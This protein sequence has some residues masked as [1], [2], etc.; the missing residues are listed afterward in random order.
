VLLRF[1]VTG[2]VDTELVSIEGD[3]LGLSK[4]V[5]SAA[6]E[7]LA[8]DLGSLTGALGC[9]DWLDREFKAM[10][11][12]GASFGTAAAVGLVGRLWSASTPAANLKA[13][14]EIMRAGGPAKRARQ[15][16]EKLPPRVRQALDESAKERAQDLLDQLPGLT[17]A[18]AKDEGMARPLGLAWLRRRDDLEA[19]AFLSRSSDLRQLLSSVDRAGVCENTLWGVLGPFGDDDRLRAVSWQEPE[20]WWGNLAVG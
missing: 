4:W 3:D 8:P 11:V 19:I 13:T 2:S 10:A 17:A 6:I 14:P 18:L 15:W 7:V 9:P 5:P 12:A 16:F 1:N 20:S